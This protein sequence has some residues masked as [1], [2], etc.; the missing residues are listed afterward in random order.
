M[1]RAAFLAAMLSALALAAPAGAVDVGGGGDSMT[2]TPDSVYNESKSPPPGG[3]PPP[4]GGGRPKV[5]GHRAGAAG[6]AGAAG[7]SGA[8]SR[9]GIG[10]RAEDAAR[11][12]GAGESGANDLAMKA[13]VNLQ[14][15]D[16]PTACRFA[17]EAL[18]LEPRNK[19]ALSVERAACRAE[20]PDPKKVDAPQPRD[21]GE[22]AGGSPQLLGTQQ[23]GGAVAEAAAAAAGPGQAKRV[24][25]ASEALAREEYKEALTIVDE[26][27]KESPQDEGLLL[28][29][30]MALHKL[31]LP[32]SALEILEKLDAKTTKDA[33][34]QALRSLLL[35]E[36][37]DFAGAKE[38]MRLAA[39]LDPQ[40]YEDVLRQMLRANVLALFGKQVKLEAP[41]GPG[42]LA[43][44]GGAAAAG[45]VVMLLAALALRG[46]ASRGAAASEDAPP[47]AAGPLE[48]GTLVAGQY[49]IEGELG[50]GGMGVVYAG[51]DEKLRRPVALKRLQSELRE[52][53]EDLDRFL[54]EARLVAQLKHPN[55]ASIYNVVEHGPDVLLVFERVEG[56]T[57]AAA[58]AGGN[59][60][61]PD[62]AG[63]VLAHV[64]AG[65]EHA[66]AHRIIHRDLKPSNLMIAAD[67]SVKVM[68]FGVAH[69]AQGPDTTSTAAS[70]TLPY[71][72][73][74]Q[75]LGSVSKASDLY[76]LGVM[77]YEMLCGK[78]P[79]DGPDYAGPKLKKQFLPITRRRILPPG[80]DAFFDSALDP[81]PAKRPP[82][83]AA[84]VEAFQKAL[85]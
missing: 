11:A 38:A 75:A 55:V 30:A 42:M 39:G 12:A 41:A 60:L 1:N 66:H 50:R 78:R 71:M 29:K 25:A 63:R 70:G 52:S 2:Q 32:D 6:G 35:A 67:G 76:A 61:T 51:M 24:A 8:P 36:K 4:S 65:L 22:S 49:R 64:A 47:A 40:T 23:S 81:D 72:A 68:D 85:V 53:D 13:G 46:L 54:K 58:L 34:A 59:S 19:K 37:G 33:E 9:G 74:E 21:A 83:A 31:N 82:S 20:T 28:L 14:L 45:F 17:R 79:F 43:W 7:S 48:P 44:V 84:F 27:L 62:E 77:T 73:P 10:E 18:K 57:L 56:R 26:G 80:L 5:I 15:G 69:Q 3:T 16:L